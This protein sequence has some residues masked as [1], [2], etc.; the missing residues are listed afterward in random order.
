MQ[1]NNHFPSE[2]LEQVCARAVTYSADAMAALRRLLGAGASR[3]QLGQA[4]EAVTRIEVQM[5]SLGRELAGL[6]DCA[7][8]GAG[9]GEALRDQSG[10][11]DREAGQLSQLSR[12]LGEMP[13]TRAKLGGGA[14][15]LSNAVALANAY[16]PD[17]GEGLPKGTVSAPGGGDAFSGPGSSGGSGWLI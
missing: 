12:R 4:A 7:D 17:R 10:V 9:S 15:T 5:S 11:S 3:V 6:L 2:T 1:H 16:G 13:N 14:T 8:G